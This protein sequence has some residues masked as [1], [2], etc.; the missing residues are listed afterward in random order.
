MSSESFNNL[1]KEN[2]NIKNL[3]SNLISKL[4]TH[5]NNIISI[6]TNSTEEEIIMLYNKIQENNY[7][8]EKMCAYNRRLIRNVTYLRDIKCE[9]ERIVDHHNFDIG[10][11]CYVC[12]KCGMIM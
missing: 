8:I 11:T 6:D 7:E 10:H 2:E 5:I 4:K 1:I 12:K 3:V 9:H